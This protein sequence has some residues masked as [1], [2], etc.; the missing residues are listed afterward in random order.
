MTNFGPAWTVSSLRHSKLR[1]EPGEAA[2]RTPTFHNV[3]YFLTV[4]SGA[5]KEYY[6]SKARHTSIIDAEQSFFFSLRNLPRPNVV[7]STVR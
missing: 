4:L 2:P 3:G 7:E 6:K 5:V 1:R